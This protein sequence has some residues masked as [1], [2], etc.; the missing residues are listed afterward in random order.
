LVTPADVDAAEA[1]HG[2]IPPGAI[3]LI[4]TGWDARW[5]DRTRYLGT[6]VPGDTAHLHFPGLAAPAAE[7]LVARGVHAVGIDTASIDHGPSKAFRAHRVL[8][9]ATVPIFENLMDLGTLP[10]RGATFIGL[11]MKIA[12]GTGAPLRAIAVLP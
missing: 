4:R 2:R 12:G 11:P 10:P 1:A 3:V 8:T 7:R 5:P 6:A 9:N